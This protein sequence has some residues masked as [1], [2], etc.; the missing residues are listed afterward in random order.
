MSQI[1]NIMW[2]LPFS[3]SSSSEIISWLWVETLQTQHSLS[4]SLRPFPTQGSHMN[5]KITC[6][7]VTVVFFWEGYLFCLKKWTTLLPRYSAAAAKWLQLC[8]TLCDPIDGSPPR[9]PIPGIL[10]WTQNMSSR[11]FQAP[12]CLSE[13]R[14]HN[15]QLQTGTKWPSCFR[16]PR[17]DIPSSAVVHRQERT[18]VRAVIPHH[19]AGGGGH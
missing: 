5:T 13:G 8:P 1:S 14:V 16:S 11:D 15:N 9:S 10:R 7:K 4:L 2:Y 18:S 12:E 3:D 6:V 19:C 17:A